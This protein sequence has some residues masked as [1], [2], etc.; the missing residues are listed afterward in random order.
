M[1]NVAQHTVNSALSTG[2]SLTRRQF[3]AAAL[4]T[5]AGAPF[6]S[7]VAQA[8][9]ST[10]T[11][12]PTT[13]L[14]TQPTTQPTTAESNAGPWWMGPKYARSRVVENRSDSALRNMIPAPGAV[15]D[16]LGKAVGALV[17]ESSSEGAW[18]TILGSSKRITIRVDAFAADVLRTGDSMI[19]VLVQELQR[20]DYPTESITVVNAPEY[21]YRAL[22]V[23]KPVIGW[24]A[25][26]PV[27][28][29]REQLANWLFESD[30]IIN[31][32]FL[33]AAPIGGMSCCTNTLAYSLVRHPAKYYLDDGPRQIA[34]VLA[35]KQVHSRLRL[36]VVNALRVIIDGGADATEA[37]IVPYGG[38]LVGFDPVAVDSV[39]L[40]LLLHERRAAELGARHAPHIEEAVRL[41]L[42]R[43]EVNELECVMLGPRR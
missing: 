18:R 30:A 15:E 36:N 11:T 20:A 9:Q 41:G 32:P 40:D 42:G 16:L 19:R 22:G 24:G 37:Q 35:D 38:L 31:V 29:N 28:E 6:V 13:Q 23:R 14:T 2:N 34:Q 4:G 1:L 39:A 8:Q 3:V 27:G 21:L 26:A 25:A 17:D 10:P 5:L 7:H 33:A 43:R 12:A